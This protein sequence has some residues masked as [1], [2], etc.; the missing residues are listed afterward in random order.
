MDRTLLLLLLLLV[1]CAPRGLRD[2]DLLFVSEDPGAFAGAVDASTG[3]GGYS[4]V[5]IVERRWNGV[6]VLEA[7]PRKGVVRTPFK[8]FRS[9]SGGVSVRRFP[10][11]AVAARSVSLARTYLGRPYDAAFLPGTDALYCSE[12]VAVS[13]LD[14][15]GA[16][17]FPSEPMSFSDTS[18]VLP[19]WTAY[20]DSLGVRIPEGE[21]GTNPNGLSAHPSLLSIPL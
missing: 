1:S 9:E 11:P 3:A 15:A 5:G 17:V 12:L 10:D 13:F 4:H 16:P 2:G 21:P 18:G 8:A 20:Y 6:F 14:A 19:F 7:V